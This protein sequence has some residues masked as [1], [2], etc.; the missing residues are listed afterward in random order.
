M[1]NE[2]AGLRV[3]CLAT[4]GV[5]QVELL[6]P[7]RALAG[8]GAQVEVASPSGE[9]IIAFNHIERGDLIPADR[10]L[11]D[12]DPSEFDSLFLPGGVINGDAL[13]TNEE[14]IAI[15]QSFFEEGKPVAVICHGPWILL[16]ACVVGG[17]TLT[18]WH[19]LQ[20]DIRNAG[21]RWVDQ[22]VCVD[23]NLVSS[24]KPDDLPVFIEKMVDLFAS[25][26]ARGSARD[27]WRRA[28]PKDK[29]DEASRESFPASD[30]PTHW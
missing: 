28:R 15:V 10:K 16:D 25:L 26:P 23:G 12:V 21:A 7:M 18:S 2:L 8:F 14:A 4:D 17:R 6:E 13:R 24:R 27:R 19:S 29:V 1:D 5:E 3:L 20:T 22:E 9:A 11:A 30:A